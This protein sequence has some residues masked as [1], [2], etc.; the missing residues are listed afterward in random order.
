MQQ[1]HEILTARQ[2]DMFLGVHHRPRLPKQ[3]PRRTVKRQCDTLTPRRPIQRVQKLSDRLDVV[4]DMRNQG[5][6]G[7][8]VQCR[9]VSRPTLVPDIDIEDA[10]FSLELRKLGP[11]CWRWLDR[12]HARDMQCQRQRE[13][14]CASADV[15]PVIRWLRQRAERVEGRVIAATRVSSKRARQR[16]VVIATVRLFPQPLCLLPIPHDTL[17]PR[18]RQALR[19]LTVGAGVNLAHDHIT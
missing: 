18:L 10:V 15:E 12:D 9:I 17:S 4:T 5:H 6:I 16:T 19:R 2:L 3:R 7:N 11:H 13:P 8:V 14:S 1:R